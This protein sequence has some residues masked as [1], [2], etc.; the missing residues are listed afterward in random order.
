MLTWI[1]GGRASP[2]PS[3]SERGDIMYVTWSDL[4]AFVTMLTAVIAL[5]IKIHK[6]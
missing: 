6:K 4:I 5:V 1:A 3:L 2:V